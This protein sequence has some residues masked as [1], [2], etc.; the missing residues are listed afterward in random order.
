VYRLNGI[1]AVIIVKH[2]L[3]HSKDRPLDKI[4]YTVSTQE[5]RCTLFSEHF[6]R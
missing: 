4:K 6:H 3:A 1:Y 5:V 2:I